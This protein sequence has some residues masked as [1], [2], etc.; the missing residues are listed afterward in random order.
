MNTYWW[1]FNDH[2]RRLTLKK[3]TDKS[4]IFE[5][6]SGEP[7]RMTLKTFDDYKA[8]GCI[9]VV[10]TMTILMSRSQFDALQEMQAEIDRLVETRRDD[11]DIQRLG[12][13]LDR[14]ATLDDRMTP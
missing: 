10:D 8:R 11:H 2:W 5:Y 1:K 14:F 9:L 13:L 6:P 3:F 7:W 12:A 4:V